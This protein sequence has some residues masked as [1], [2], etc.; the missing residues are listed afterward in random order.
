MGAG[1][2]RA[3]PES[4]S[5][6]SR[7]WEWRKNFPGPKEIQHMSK[8]ADFA[9]G[10]PTRGHRERVVPQMTPRILFWRHGWVIVSLQRKVWGERVSSH[11]WSWPSNQNWTKP[12]VTNNRTTEQNVRS[13]RFQHCVIGGERLGSPRER[14]STGQALRSPWTRAWVHVP[15]HGAAGGDPRRTW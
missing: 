6:V 12:S 15:D 4:L 5:P 11:F 3:R 2:N 7:L 10:A 14:E 1:W 9:D 13:H 8:G